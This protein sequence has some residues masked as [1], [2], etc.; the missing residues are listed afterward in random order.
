MRLDRVDGPVQATAD[1]GGVE[2][3][4]LA[5]GAKVRTSGGDVTIDGFA[6][7]VEVDVERGSTRLSPRAPVAAD[8]TAQAKGGEVHLEV[9]EGSRF[10]LDAESRRGELSVQVPGLTTSETG[11]EPGRAHH[12]AGKLDGG[13]ASV[14]LRADGDVT[15]EAKPAGPSPIAR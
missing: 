11:G 5:K 6:G 12:V 8:V 10:D 4:G 9:P 7:P 3:S 13:G 14:H 2:A 1:H 15:L